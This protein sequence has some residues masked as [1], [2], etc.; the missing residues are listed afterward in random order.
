MFEFV[1]SLFRKRFDT[2]NPDYVEYIVR[3]AAY[4]GFFDCTRH[5]DDLRGL[6]PFDVP[7]MYHDDYLRGYEQGWSEAENFSDPEF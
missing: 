5:R 6:V 3:E 1:R 7:K 2:Y 4:D